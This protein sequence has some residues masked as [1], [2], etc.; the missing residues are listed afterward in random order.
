MQN[1]NFI[2]TNS[3]GT[4][5]NPATMTAE[6]YKN[7]IYTPE[8]MDV[9]LEEEDLKRAQD[10]FALNNLLSSVLPELVANNP[11]GVIA[12]SKLPNGLFFISKPGVTMYDKSPKPLADLEFSAADNEGNYLIYQL[13]NNKGGARTKVAISNLEGEER[14]QLIDRVEE[15]LTK[16]G[17][18][19]SITSLTDAYVAAVLLPDGTYALV[20][21]KAK[22]IDLNTKFLELINRAE[23]TLS[24]NPE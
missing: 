14:R 16:Q 6:E 7:I 21:L 18:L 10:N 9:N 23:T 22:S 11:D 8:G 1:T 12:L 2:I 5:I 17:L 20:N 19:D 3:Q 24:D 13:E 15:G 4:V